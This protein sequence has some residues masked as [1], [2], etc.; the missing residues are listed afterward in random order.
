MSAPTNNPLAVVQDLLRRVLLEGPGQ[1]R[2]CAPADAPEWE[3]A[4]GAVYPLLDQLAE[5]AGSVRT[6]TRE[7]SAR[8]IV[9][10]ALVEANAVCEAIL[11]VLLDR[12]PVT[13]AIVG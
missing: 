9:E 6:R 2:P 4:L 3:A 7:S 11:R 10:E 13:A 12:K 8:S 1:I 5:A